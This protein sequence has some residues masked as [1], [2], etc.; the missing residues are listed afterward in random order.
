MKAEHVLHESRTI[1]KAKKSSC[2]TKSSSLVA[3]P[4]VRPVVSIEPAALDLKTA[5]QFLGVTLRQMRTLCYLRKLVPVRLGKKQIIL[6][7]DLREFI[8]KMREAA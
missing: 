8:L 4:S 3:A 6:T 7:A 5:A 2:Q 1:R